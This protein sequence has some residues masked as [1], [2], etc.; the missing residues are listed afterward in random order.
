MTKTRFF[1][2]IA[3]LGLCCG[4]GSMTYLPKYLKYQ[5]G[6]IKEFEEVEAGELQ[7]GDLVQGVIDF[8]DGC[9]AENEETKSTM[10]IETSRRTA[11]QYYAVYMYNDQYILYETSN[12]AQYQ[13]LDKLANECEMYYQSVDEVYG[14]GGSENAEDLIQPTTT[15][16][17]TAVVQKMP[18][19]LS[20]IFREWYGEGFDQ[21]CETV[22]LRY[23]DFSTLLRNVL[24]GAGLLALGVIF[25][26]ITIISW[27]KSKQFSY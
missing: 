7:A 21:D 15:M 5:K 26:I 9:I 25:L 2:V 8:T 19:D 10:G 4:I 14:E 20:A 24:I 18:D 17:F 22:M 13:T 11:S 16:E 1:L 23:T 6:D 12:Q 3:L 27:R